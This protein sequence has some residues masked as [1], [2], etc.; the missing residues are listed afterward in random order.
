MDKNKI[1]IIALIIVIIALACGLFATMSNNPKYASNL[2]ITSNSTLYE[3]DSICFKLMDSNNTPIANQTL[4][5]TIKDVNNTTSYSVVTNSSGMAELKPNMSEGNYTINAT[6]YGN[7]NFTENSAVQ[8]ITIEK[9][10]DGQASNSHSSNSPSS[11]E[12]DP[13]KG[14]QEYV[15]KWDESQSGDGNWAYTHDQPVKT[16][17]EGHSYKRMYDEGSGESYWYQ[18]N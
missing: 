18:M 10:A 3:G 17:D 5:V 16:D 11:T 8:E 7:E 9:S 14:T 6:F 4:N 1:L 12:S 15:D 13:A 2:T